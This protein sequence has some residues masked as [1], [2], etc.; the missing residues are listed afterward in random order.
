MRW[1]LFLLNCWHF[2]FSPLLLKWYNFPPGRQALPPCL[3]Y[4]SQMCRKDWQILKQE[5]PYLYMECKMSRQIFK[6]RKCFYQ[7]SVPVIWKK[8]ISYA[9]FQVIIKGKLCAIVIWKS[10]HMLRRQEFTS[11]GT[12]FWK[13][14]GPWKGCLAQNNGTRKESLPSFDDTSAYL[15]LSAL[16]NPNHCSYW[17]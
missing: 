2:C 14:G 9:I 17:K 3:P 6:A 1:V 7:T 11:A 12:N 5:F 13:N 15:P 4:R 16:D 10:H 8:S